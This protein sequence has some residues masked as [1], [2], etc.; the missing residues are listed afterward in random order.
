M[1]LNISEK[2]NMSCDLGHLL[3]FD[4]Q[5]FSKDFVNEE[6]ISERAKSNLQHCFS[7]LFKLASTQKGEDDEKRDFDK[8]EDN[9]QLPKPETILPRAKPIPRPKPLTKW[10]KYRNE[11][12][13]QP[14]E[15]RSRMV[16]SDTAGDWVPRWG[17]GSAKQIE[18]KT[19]WAIEETPDMQGKDPFALKKQQKKLES[20]KQQKR[21]M[22]NTEN[23]SKSNEGKNGKEKKDNTPKSPRD[24][25]DAKAGKVPRDTS[26]AKGPKEAK[27]GKVPR[28]TIDPRGPRDTK[29]PKGEKPVFNKKVARHEKEQQKLKKDKKGLEKTLET[30]NLNI[31]YLL[32]INYF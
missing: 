10:E 7:E 6:D 1:T 23:R 11:K 5:P 24:A 2:F 32:T 17:K 22:K 15:K 16:F 31:I 9:V 4:N 25:K 13:I 18:N 30:G 28:V 12:G 21:E 29:G 8:P 14:R 27:E 26:E 3:V 19:E 20:M